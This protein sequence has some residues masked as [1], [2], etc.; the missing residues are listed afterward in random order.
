[1]LRNTVKAR[2][3][4]LIAMVCL[5][6][7]NN[8]SMQHLALSG[9]QPQYISYDASGKMIAV[10]WTGGQITLHETATQQL[11]HAIHLDQN[12]SLH[13]GIVSLSPDGTF[14]GSIEGA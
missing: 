6:V 2:I 9:Q 10:A 13:R 11:L 8:Q 3:I 12:R 5:S 1:M 14:L 4:H 7:L